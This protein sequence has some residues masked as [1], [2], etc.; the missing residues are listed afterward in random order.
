MTWREM[1]CKKGLL[2]GSLGR[3]LHRGLS[4][5]LNLV[6]PGGLLYAAPVHHVA[7]ALSEPKVRR[8]A[9]ELER[10]HNL[11]PIEPLHLWPDEAPGCPRTPAEH[12]TVMAS[13]QADG[14]R[15][16]LLAPAHDRCV[17]ARHLRKAGQG[18]HHVA[19]EVPDIEATT[20]ML[21]A[22]GLR[23]ITDLADDEP[24]LKQVFFKQDPDPRIV[25]LVERASGFDGTFKCGNLRT[26]IDGERRN[27][28]AAAEETMPAQALSPVWF[29]Y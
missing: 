2:P 15:V 18:L 19:F 11:H 22:L 13:F 26:L 3:L 24:E 10:K 29:L 20:A 7:L 8:W 5:P 27:A 16:V 1:Q 14:F 21:G 4:N 23:Q 25:E 9:A 28:F 12:Q 17:L 6:R